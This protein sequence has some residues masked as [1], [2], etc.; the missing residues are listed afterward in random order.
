MFNPYIILAALAAFLLSGVGGYVK[1]YSDADQRAKVA[2]MQTALNAAYQDLDA[3]RV[4]A[5]HSRKAAEENGKAAI[6][7]QEQIDAYETELQSRGGAARCVIGDDDLIRLRQYGHGSDQ[8][9]TKR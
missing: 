2:E 9:A 4:A 6:R 3:Q 7:A 8:N 1:G 5:E